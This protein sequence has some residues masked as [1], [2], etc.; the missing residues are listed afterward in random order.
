MPRLLRA[1]FTGA[2]RGDIGPIPNFPADYAAGVWAQHLQVS[3][4]NGVRY[5]DQGDGS[6]QSKALPAAVK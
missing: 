5:L 2:R 1:L 6:F 3:E 4:V